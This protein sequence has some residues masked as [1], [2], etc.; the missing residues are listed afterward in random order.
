MQLS[1]SNRASTGTVDLG[2]SYCKL[3]HLKLLVMVLFDSPST[4]AYQLSV[5]TVSI[6]YRFRDIS[7]LSAYMTVCDLQ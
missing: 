6:W 1:L 7:I 2:S 5:V 4:I 3:R